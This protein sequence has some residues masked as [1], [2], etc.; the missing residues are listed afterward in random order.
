MKKILEDFALPLIYASFWLSIHYV[1]LGFSFPVYS[2]AVSAGYGA[3]HYLAKKR[4]GH[5]GPSADS[6]AAPIAFGIAIISILV[7]NSTQIMPTEPEAW[8]LTATNLTLAFLFSFAGGHA[9]V[10]LS[11]I[12]YSMIFERN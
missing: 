7:A 4:K 6:L 10:M 2:L 3:G 9:F 1:M 11:A 12:I 5:I 8:T